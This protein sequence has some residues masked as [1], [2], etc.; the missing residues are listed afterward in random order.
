M[1]R[2]NL[3]KVA[4]VPGMVFENPAQEALRRFFSEMHLRNMEAPIRIAETLKSVDL[5]WWPEFLLHNAREQSEIDSFT[6]SLQAL[7]LAIL[8]EESLA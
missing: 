6:A 2:Q 5:A 4:F 7:N 1:R 8:E 3:P